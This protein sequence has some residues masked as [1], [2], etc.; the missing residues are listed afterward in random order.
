MI[1]VE[2]QVVVLG[3]LKS[4]FLERLLRR[5][6]RQNCSA[7]SYSELRRIQ[8]AKEQTWT[9]KCAHLL[10]S[11]RSAR[12]AGIR[13]LEFTRRVHSEDVRARIP[14]DCGQFDRD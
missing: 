11:D 6:R 12:N 3:E 10:R 5:M 4:R 8:R 1:E 9:D 14:G 7:D 13:E 2:A